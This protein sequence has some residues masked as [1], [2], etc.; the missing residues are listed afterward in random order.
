MSTAHF[1]GFDQK[2]LQTETTR[3]G[4]LQRIWPFFVFNLKSK[5]TYSR[6]FVSSFFQNFSNK[7]D[8]GGFAFGAGN[9]DHFHGTRWES[10]TH[11]A[12]MSQQPMIH[13]LEKFKDRLWDKD[14]K[15]T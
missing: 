11:R 10:V 5:R 7:E 14:R 3:H 9:P 8:G 13:R 6:Y 12:G 4:H 15:S 1:F 2:F